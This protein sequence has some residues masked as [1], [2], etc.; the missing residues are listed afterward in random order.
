[1]SKY[2][3]ALA[4]AVAVQAGKGSYHNSDDDHHDLQP[5]YGFI[6]PISLGIYDGSRRNKPLRGNDGYL[7]KV[8]TDPYERLYDRVNAK[9]VLK[10]PEEESHINGVIYLSQGA[11][12]A[13]TKI[14]GDINAI[15]DASYGLN[16]YINAL[17]DLTGGCDSAGA[18]FNPSVSASGYNGGYE[19][20][21]APGDLGA[22]NVEDYS[23]YVKLYADVD[24][25]GSQSIIGRAMTVVRPKY[26][27]SYGKKYAEVRVACCTIGIAAGKKYSAPKYDEV[28]EY[29]TEPSYKPSYKKY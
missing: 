28:K 16:F 5:T 2:A 25:S 19:P 4:M 12:D 23:A 14:W 1:M 9:C 18:V 3:A 21:Y 20:E 10:D 8:R 17:G 29:K 7:V 27:D 11:T 26:T 6:T 22:L 24:L 13:T 15:E